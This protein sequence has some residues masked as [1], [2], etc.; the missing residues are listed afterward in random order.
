MSKKGGDLN[1]GKLYST[2]MNHEEHHDSLDTYVSTLKQ[3]TFQNII[4]SR[5]NP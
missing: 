2:K 3:F 1:F 5:K 4:S